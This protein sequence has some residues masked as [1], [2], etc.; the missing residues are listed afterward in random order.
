MRAYT[1][2]CP[3]FPSVF[4][5]SPSPPLPYEAY[6]PAGDSGLAFQRLCADVAA[7][8]A[9]EH[10]RG[11][12]RRNPRTIQRRIGEID[13]QQRLQREKSR[14]SPRAGELGRSEQRAHLAS[15]RSNRALLTKEDPLC[16]K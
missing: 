10:P 8:A 16:R 2:A 12:Q 1:R 15:P 11:C 3:P 13:Q 7:A 5:L 14:T 6:A 9:A 4:P